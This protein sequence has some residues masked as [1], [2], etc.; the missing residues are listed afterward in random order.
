MAP[1]F[2]LYRIQHGN[3]VGST[4]LADEQKQ[5]C[6]KSCTRHFWDIT[7]VTWYSTE[8]VQRNINMA[9]TSSPV[10]HVSGMS[11]I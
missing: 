3:V 2:L 6:N 9:V 10:F 1:I 8:Y 7:D 11:V 4:H 5:G